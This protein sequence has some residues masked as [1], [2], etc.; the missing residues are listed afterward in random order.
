MI[1]ASGRYSSYQT[2]YKELKLGRKRCIYRSCRRYQTTY[3][4]LKRVPEMAGKKCPDRYQTTYK[5][6]K[7]QT[8]PV[9]SLLPCALSDYL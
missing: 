7:H 1:C 8:T 4:E 3:K 9:L 5:E 2:T 6:L